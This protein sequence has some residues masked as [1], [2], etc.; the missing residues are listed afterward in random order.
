[1]KKSIAV[2]FGGSSNEREVSLLSAISIIEHLDS[3]KYT[4]Y[5]IGITEDN[6]FLLC[7]SDT[8][9]NGCWEREGEDCLLFGGFA[10]GE[11]FEAYIDAAILA[12]HGQNCEDGKLQGFLYY[13]QIPY[14]GCGCEAS[15]VCMDKELT[16]LVL[17]NASLPVARYVV[18]KADDSLQKKLK[19]LE[20]PIFI[21]PARSGSSVGVSR[22]DSDNELDGALERAFLTDKKILAEE[23]IEGKEIEV[24]VLKSKDGRMI[25]SEPAEIDSG[26]KFY[27]YSAKY[28]SNSSRHYIPARIDGAKTAA[29]REM[30]RRAFEA[31]ECE[32]LARIDFFVGDKIIINEVNTLPGFTDISM[33]PRLMDFSGIDFSLLLDIL[34]ET[35]RIK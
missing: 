35:A 34:I 25:V 6:R 31:L 17:A 15:A 4:V 11:R 18:I 32:G 5:P 1:M 3:T 19:N 27:D 21:K 20:Y 8:L 10:V 22:I 30:A 23:Y 2:F 7:Q 26:A 24:A 28:E 13:S 14:V 29:V 12:I 33:Y 9:R 16:K